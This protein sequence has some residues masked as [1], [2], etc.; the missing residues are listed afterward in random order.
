MAAL[1]K[2]PLVYICENNQYGMGTSTKRSSASDEYYKRGHYVP[3]IKVDGMNVLAVSALSTLT[4][5]LTNTGTIHRQF[6]SCS[7]GQ[8]RSFIKSQRSPV[9]SRVICQGALAEALPVLRHDVP[10]L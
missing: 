10:L 2:L 3:G 6:C 7:Y 9:L 5:E 1:W 8:A 4:F